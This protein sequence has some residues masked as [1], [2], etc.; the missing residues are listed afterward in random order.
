[1]KMFL[2]HNLFIIINTLLHHR[3]KLVKLKVKI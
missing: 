2:T 1:M 3:R